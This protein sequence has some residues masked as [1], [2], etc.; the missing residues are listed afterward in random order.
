MGLDAAGKT[1][2]LY[3]LKLNEMVTTI[4]TVGMVEFYIN[5]MR[6]ESGQ[7]CVHFLPNFKTAINILSLNIKIMYKI[8]LKVLM[9][10]R[11][12]IKT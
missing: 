2:I 6:C 12:I 9:W 7:F 5:E 10:R 3:K 11:S 4:P 1:S 8:Q